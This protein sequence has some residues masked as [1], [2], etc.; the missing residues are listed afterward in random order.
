MTEL[1]Q[2]FTFHNR[3]YAPTFL[4]LR[5]EHRRT[6]GSDASPSHASGHKNKKRKSKGKAAQR[7][8]PEFVKE[9]A[10]LLSKLLEDAASGGDDVEEDEGFECGCCF[11]S[12]P[13]VRFS[14][15]PMIIP[16][17][18]ADFVLGGS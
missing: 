17:K 5:T 18:A 15:T 10:W 16:K 7:T 14:P 8:D 2:H 12:Y 11:S 6:G 3:L 9:R 1:I 4:S 13:F